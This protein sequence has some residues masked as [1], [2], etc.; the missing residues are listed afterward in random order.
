MEKKLLFTTIILCF[1]SIQSFSQGFGGGVHVGLNASQVDG[2]AV[3]GFNKAGLSLGAFVNYEIGDN[4]FIQ[5]ELLFEQLGSASQGITFVQTSH[6]SLP[7]VFKITIPVQMGNTTQAIQLHAGPAIG[8]LIGAK[9]DVGNDLSNLLKN[10][11]T[12]I[13]GGL[14]YRLAP[15]FSFMLR[16]GYSLGSF[17]ET[18]A[19]TAANLLAPGKTGLAHNYV[20][21]GLRVH[22]TAN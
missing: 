5:P 7:I 16:Y 10:F 1:L 2:D 11:D 6:V 9:N 17:I 21:L 13:V 18:T 22:F 15:G 14:S 12:R 19:P 4:I 20:N 3:S 8:L